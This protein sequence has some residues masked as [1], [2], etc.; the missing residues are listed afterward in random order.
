MFRTWR[1]VGTRG[2]LA[3]CVLVSAWSCA[4]S[5]FVEGQLDTAG[6]AGAGGEDASE[7]SSGSSN[8]GGSGF[9]PNGGTASGGGSSSSG[10]L[11]PGEGGSSGA[12]SVSALR[13][14]STTPVADAIA[15]SREGI[16]EATFSA[17]IDEASITTESFQVTGPSGPVDGELTVD[18]GL[19]AFVGEVLP[20]ATQIGA[21]AHGVLYRRPHDPS[22]V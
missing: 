1:S 2:S 9:E 14:L 16:V 17:P 7:A 19:G 15:V 13:L 21:T 11:P 4:G 3:L 8:D 6:A 18:G 5:D 20:P 22:Q 10:G 12:E